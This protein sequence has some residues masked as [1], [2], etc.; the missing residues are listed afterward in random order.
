MM[1]SD[2]INVSQPTRTGRRELRLALAARGTTI[3]ARP[4]SLDARLYA[5]LTGDLIPTDPVKRREPKRPAGIS[6]RQ[7][8]RLRKAERRAGK[9]DKIEKD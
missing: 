7:A 8:K 6:A 4:R 1:N 9:I 3:H 2:Q 5:S